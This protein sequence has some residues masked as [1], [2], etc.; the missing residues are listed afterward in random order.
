[1]SPWRHSASVHRQ[2]IRDRPPK[3]NDTGL[4][5]KEKPGLLSAAPVRAF[6]QFQ[7]QGERWFTGAG[8]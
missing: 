6:D 4:G 8:K 1:M 3:T 5:F 2:I 7:P